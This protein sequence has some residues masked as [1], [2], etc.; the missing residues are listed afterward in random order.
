MGGCTSKSR[1][2]ARQP[3]DSRVNAS[4]LRTGD[5]VFFTQNWTSSRLKRQI[6]SVNDRMWTSGGVVI[7]APSLYKEPM[8][9]EYQKSYDDDHLQDALRLQQVTG[10]VR[11]V[12]LAD[13][14]K[15]PN[16]EA[17]LI[18]KIQHQDGLVEIQRKH[19]AVCA[20]MIDRIRDSEFPN[21]AYMIVNSLHNS[22]IIKT[23]KL[24]IGVTLSDCTSAS[25]NNLMPAPDFYSDGKIYVVK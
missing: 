20:G 6:R 22:G 4:K 16:Y 19:T 23:N 10:G 15:L 25:F 9:L 3:K 11:L 21:P 1:Q 12:S 24:P 14:L 2:Y 13:R 7:H 18:R 5:L 17:C 8:L